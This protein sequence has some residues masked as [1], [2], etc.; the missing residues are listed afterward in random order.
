ML[1]LC[2]G[3]LRL[4]YSLLL[5]RCLSLKIQRYQ[6]IENKEKWKQVRN[7]CPERTNRQATVLQAL[8]VIGRY[9]SVMSMHHS[10]PPLPSTTPFDLS[11]NVSECAHHPPLL[12]SAPF[13][14]FFSQI[15]VKA[16]AQLKTTKNQACY[17]SYPKN[18][19]YYPS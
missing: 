14:L 2:F 18:Q 12:L 7:A 17:P 5:P 11:L 19:V 10:L 15:P 16:S 9:T 13:F 1:C 8:F 4:P 3:G 6:K